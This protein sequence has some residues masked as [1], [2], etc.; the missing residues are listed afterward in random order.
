MVSFY[1]K[2]KLCFAFV[3]TFSVMPFQSHQ[4][5]WHRSQYEHCCRM[6]WIA[7]QCRIRHLSILLICVSSLHLQRSLPSFI[8]SS[9]IDLHR[10]MIASAIAVCE[11]LII[12]SFHWLT[13]YLQPHSV[14]RLLCFIRPHTRNQSGFHIDIF[15]A[16]SFF[17]TIHAMC[18]GV[19]QQLTSINI[20]ILKNYIIWHRFFCFIIRLCLHRQTKHLLHTLPTNISKY[21]REDA[22]GSRK[23]KR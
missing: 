8:F 2:N 4:F 9:F 16:I 23:K 5:I 18:Y 21:Q 17:P 22:H 3:S 14:I 1:L 7:V 15:K 6:H 10:F 13:Q 20:I 12:Q 19:Q 11:S